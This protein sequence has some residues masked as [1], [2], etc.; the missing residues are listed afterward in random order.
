VLLALRG[1][2]PV[3][4]VHTGR[5][6]DVRVPADQ[7]GDQILRHVV[8]VETGITLRGHPRVEQHLQQH[9]AELLANGGPIAVLDRLVELVALLDQVRQ[10]RLVGLLGVPRAATR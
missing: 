10:Q 3:G 4:G 5:G 1:V 9:V 2:D 8:D 6:E 7:L